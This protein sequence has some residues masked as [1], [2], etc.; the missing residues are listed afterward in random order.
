[1]SRN[2]E[3]S[4]VYILE[5]YIVINSFIKVIIVTYL[6]DNFSKV[7]NNIFIYNKKNSTR[8]FSINN[9]NTINNYLA[10]TYIKYF[11]SIFT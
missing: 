1:M 3:K 8:G 10:S 2:R 9:V 5:Y 7:I 11:L 6:L 4:C